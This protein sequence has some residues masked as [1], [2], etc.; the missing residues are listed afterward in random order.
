MRQDVLG[1]IGPNR[2][3]MET[4][5]GELLKVREAA[6]DRDK[7]D[8]GKPRSIIENVYL[9]IEKSILEAI[10][11]P[12]IKAHNKK[13]PCCWRLSMRLLSNLQ[14][15]LD[16]TQHTGKVIKTINNVWNKALQRTITLSRSRSSSKD[17]R[18]RQDA[19]RPPFYSSPSELA[20]NLR[21]NIL[22]IN[23]LVITRQTLKDVLSSSSIDP[24]LGYPQ[25]AIRPAE[26][27][28]ANH[29]GLLAK[30]PPLRFMAQKAAAYDFR[31]RS[32]DYLSQ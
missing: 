18:P 6:H 26:L 20:A 22:P 4:A 9:A 32:T 8:H 13:E 30:I 7:M 28:Y 11:W 14:K 15:R 5:R 29:Q 25:V 31:V 23:K 24:L 19:H 17:R 16:R 2:D 1:K 3:L 10:P 12:E 27:R 21:F